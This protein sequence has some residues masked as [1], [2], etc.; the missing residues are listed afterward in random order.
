[1]QQPRAVTTTKTVKQN[2]PLD[3]YFTSAFL[4]MTFHQNNRNYSYGTA[5]SWM[6]MWFTAFLCIWSIERR[7]SSSSSSASSPS[8]SS[9]PYIIWCVFIIKPVLYQYYIVFY[10]GCL[11]IEHQMPHKHLTGTTFD[12]LTINHILAKLTGQYLRLFFSFFVNAGKWMWAWGDFSVFI[13]AYAFFHVECF[14]W[15]FPTI[16]YAICYSPLSYFRLSWLILY[17]VYNSYNSSATHTS[18]V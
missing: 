9:W 14:G 16:F 11:Y 2:R 6:W 13:A 1:M 7:F 5:C 17:S 10:V 18:R 8:T 12:L 4:S 3:P 15:H